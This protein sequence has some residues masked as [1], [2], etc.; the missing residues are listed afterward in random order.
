M[1]IVRGKAEKS[2]SPVDEQVLEGLAALKEK[3]YGETTALFG[4]ARPG[5]DGI[6]DPRDTRRWLGI[7]LDVAHEA[8]G[9]T[10]RPNTFGVARL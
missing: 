9:R 2:G 1:D 6:I 8:E 3:L 7:C 4:T 5:E 10:L